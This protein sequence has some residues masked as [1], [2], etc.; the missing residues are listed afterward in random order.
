[1]Y[2]VSIFRVILWLNYLNY[3][4]LDF[5][6]HSSDLCLKFELH[7]VNDLVYISGGVAYNEAVINALKKQL[8]KDVKMIDEPQL[9]GAYG[10]ALIA[11]DK[12]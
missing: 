5:E 9:N 3:P 2:S 1:L 10:A 12:D 7:S 8:D 4:Y 6:L 11:L